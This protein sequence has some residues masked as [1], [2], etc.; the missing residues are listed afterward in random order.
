M[1]L[2]LLIARVHVSAASFFYTEGQWIKDGCGRVVILHGVNLSGANKYPDAETG[3]FFPKWLSKKTFEHLASLGFNSVRFLINWEAI[4]PQKGVF[5]ETYVAEIKEKVKWAKESG[6][7]VI[8]DM[9]QD[10][11]ARCKFN[12]NGFPCWSVLDEGLPFKGQPIWSLNY[13]QP[14]VRRAFDNF[15]KNTDDIQTHYIQ[16]WV[17][18]AKAFKEDENVVGYDLMNEPFAG[19]LYQRHDAFDVQRLQPFYER[20][21]GEIR[22]VDAHHICFIEPNPVRTNIM[23]PNGFPS[24]FT[25]LPY[26]NVALAPHFYDPVTN[27]SAKYDGDVSR[28]EKTIEG[29]MKEGERLGMPVWLG[30]FSAWGDYS[31]ISSAQNFLDDQ[32]NAYNKFFLSGWAY[33]DYGEGGKDGG[34]FGNDEKWKW[35]RDRLSFPYPSKIAGEPIK[36]TQDA[37][38]GTMFLEYGKTTSTCDTEIRFPSSLSAK[39]I[40]VKVEKGDYESVKD[41]VIIIHHSASKEMH[42]VEVKMNPK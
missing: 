11:Y 36:F 42:S 19:S 28:I 41:G 29:F 20:L 2:F 17:K 24:A 39:N 22:K 14:A 1:I 25:K 4:E 40:S 9:H 37:K 34:P 35:L 8:L 33:W 6:I 23:V 30:E 26:K 31:E 27:M 38:N 3:K 18:I 7:H 5:D 16:S 13:L 10:V 15:W 32:L 12:G 21:I